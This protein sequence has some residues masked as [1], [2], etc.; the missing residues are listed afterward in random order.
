M[1]SFRGHCGFIHTNEVWIG[2]CR[3]FGYIVLFFVLAN[4]IGLDEAQ[5]DGVDCGGWD[6]FD[7]FESLFDIECESNSGDDGV[8]DWGAALVA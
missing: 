8:L 3:S 7:P 4:F 5:T 6:P 1:W 2:F